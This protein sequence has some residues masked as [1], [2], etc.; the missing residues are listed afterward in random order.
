MKNTQFNGVDERYFNNTG[1]LGFEEL[2]QINQLGTNPTNTSGKKFDAETL[3]KVLEV[4]AT[5]VGILTGA[6]ERKAATEASK[7]ERQREKD[8]CSKN[9]AFRGQG[10]KKRKQLILDCQNKVD[11]RYDRQDALNTQIALRS[12]NTDT[13][14][15]AEKPNYLKWI[16]IGVGVIAVLGIGTY[17][18]TR[19]K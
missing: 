12:Q 14:K 19:K 18:L 3:G 8:A 10:S 16:G 2:T 9:K 7:S 13:N 15:E 5:G 11:E 17:L 6:A 1:V 4:G